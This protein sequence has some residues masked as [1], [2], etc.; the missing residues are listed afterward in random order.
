MCGIAGY[1]GEFAPDLLNAMSHVIVHRGPDDSGAWHNRADGIG[2]AQR[3]LTIIDL[4]VR[5]RQP[6]WDVTHSVVI[7]FNGEIYNYREL[8]EEL[9]AAGYEFRSTSDT[10]VL[11]NLYLQ[12]GHEMLSRL[13]GI[14]AF[15]LW[16]SRA[17]SLFVARDGLGVKPLYYSETDKGFLFGSELK[18]I[19]QVPGVNRELNTDAIHYYMSYLYCPS[20]ET[21][22]R[23]IQ[24]LEAGH[25]LIVRDGRVMRRWDFYD[26]PY[27]QPIERISER[28]AAEQLRVAVREAVRRQMVADVPVGA[29]LSGGLDSSS[30]V[31]FAREFTSGKLQCFTISFKGANWRREGMADDYGYAKRVA[32]LLDLDL[33][34]VEVGSDFTDHLE[35]AI[36]HLEEPQ[37]DPAIINTLL[38]SE[39]A[40][41]VGIKVLLSGT[42]GDDILTGYRRHQALNREWVWGWL[43]Q[44][45]RSQL[46]RLSSDLPATTAFGRRLSKAFQYADLDH[47]ERI[48]SYFSWM[49]QSSTSQLYGPSMRDHV[50]GLSTARPMLKALEKLPTSVPSLNRM[51]YLDGKFFLADHNLNYTD[52][53][54]MAAGVEIRVPLLDLDLVALAARM[55]L[56]FKQHGAIG[57]WIFKRAMEPYL[58]RDVLYRPKTGFGVPVRQWLHGELRHIVEDV[59]NSKSLKDR[60][61]FDPWAVQELIRRDCE[62]KI[63][64][65]YT[66]LA[67]LFVE[68]WCRIFLDRS[69]SF[70]NMAGVG[71]ATKLR[72]VGAE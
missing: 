58:P 2:L 38:I 33:H 71:P 47:D 63:D 21:M 52:K 53:M 12:R 70:A 35:D 39:L 67:V 62:G 69:S 60:G 66:I 31:N 43:P 8:R 20:P 59:V 36:Y 50:A 65:A 18:S 6:M 4:S 10:E 24:K 46:R 26:L 54:G 13:N 16:D 51:L 11:L 14:F 37:A 27:D 5:G 42:G 72:H 28:D 23:S 56:R 25:A 30:V 29:F 9:V 57:K 1:S 3:R 64:G 32:R 45:V 55:P 17:R 34:T 48:A 19:L 61:I 41:K 49:P 40:R 22:F 7:V 68:L 15:A 44:G